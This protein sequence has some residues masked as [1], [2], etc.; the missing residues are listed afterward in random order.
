[1]PLACFEP[2]ANTA[3]TGEDRLLLT[4]RWTSAVAFQNLTTPALCPQRARPGLV[5]GILG[6]NDK[7]H[8]NASADLI[9]RTTIIIGLTRAV[10]SKNH[11]P[12]SVRWLRPMWP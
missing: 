9:T 2:M 11:L 10:W 3:S 1:M 8:S 12:F 7:V 5:L 4:Q 6:Q